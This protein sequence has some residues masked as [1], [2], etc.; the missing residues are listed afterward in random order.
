VQATK[1]VDAL[2]SRDFGVKISSFA[3]GEFLSICIE[4]KE[5]FEKLG[6][7]PTSLLCALYG[8]LRSGEGMA[9]C[10][11]ER[12]HIG[13]FCDLVNRIRT[14]DT[15]LKPGD[16]LILAHAMSDKDCS[17]F[18]TFD[19]EIIRSVGLKNVIR[20]CLRDRKKFEIANEPS[21]LRRL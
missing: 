9:L 6:V 19:G 11:V 4:K 20:E 13:R 14:K 3:V 5:K 8:L 16:C 18:L 7:D 12:S 15:Y 17:G 2:L 21:I 1:V 10:Y